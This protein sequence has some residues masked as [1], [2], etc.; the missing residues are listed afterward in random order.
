[1]TVVHGFVVYIARYCDFME[2]PFN[3]KVKYLLLNYVNLLEKVKNLSRQLN[4]FAQVFSVG[5]ILAYSIFELLTEIGGLTG[6][7]LQQN[8]HV[9]SKITANLQAYQVNVSMHEA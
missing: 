5:Y 8:A 2:L 3:T 9:F 4:Y 7:L 1:M 6:Q